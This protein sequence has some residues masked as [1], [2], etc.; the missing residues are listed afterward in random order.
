MEIYA[1]GIP[2]DG[3]EFGVYPGGE[4]W[5][6]SHNHPV[7]AKHWIIFARIRT[8]IDLAWLWQIHDIIQQTEHDTID[9]FIPYFPGARQDRKD[10]GAPFTVQMYADFINDLDFNGVWVLDPHSDVTPALLNSVYAFPITKVMGQMVGYKGII[11]PDVGARKRADK[12]GE[13]QKLPVFQAFKHRDPTTGV[14]SNFSV[15]P[16]GV[17]RYLVVDDICDG[18]GTFAGLADAIQ[19]DFD[20]ELD[21]WVTHGIFSGAAVSN[22]RSYSKIY[23]TNSWQPTPE[24]PGADLTIVNLEDHCFPTIRKYYA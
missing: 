7:F 1:D 5:V 8:M 12:V 20:V 11:A 4:P 22:L 15:E 6:K 17:G 21:L 3:F 23:T 9:L 10:Q 24:L 16:L 18:G 2:V 19:E 14:L 13:A